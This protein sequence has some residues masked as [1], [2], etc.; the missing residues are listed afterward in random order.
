M[1]I[2]MKMYSVQLWGSELENLDYVHEF[3]EKCKEQKL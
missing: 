1:E 2:T 3:L